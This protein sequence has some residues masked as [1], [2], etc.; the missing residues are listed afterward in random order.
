MKLLTAMASALA[1]AG[2]VACASAAAP[3]PAR[4][5][6]A[7]APA[8]ITL[9]GLDLH[10]GTALTSGT[11]DYLYGTRYGCG[12]TWGTR[13]TPWCGFGVSTAKAAGGPWATPKLLFSPGAKISANWPGDNGKT[14]A[15]MCGGDGQGC[16]NPRMLHTPNG[17]WLLWFNAP[18]DKGRH[19]NPYWIMTCSGPAGPCGSPHKPAIYSACKAGGD[20]SLALQGGTGYLVCAG[21]SRAI[22]LEP[23]ATGMTNG[24][25]KDIPVPGAVGEGD[26]VYHSS[27]GY[28]LV[29]ST[30]NCGYCSGTRAAAAGA[31]AV[32]AGY[33]TAATL[34]GPWTYR[35]VLPGGTCT[36]QPRTA[37][38]LNGT[39]YVLVDRWTGSKAEPGAA[40]ALVPTAL[41]P[42][43]CK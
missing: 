36:G 10:D 30:P 13:G 9:A 2:L 11:T 20:F 17:R 28:T 34:A 22:H 24:A 43:T 12:F 15:Q 38:A 3:G 7:P 26:G 4:A 25:D 33:A 16:F 23:L 40:L 27:G 42:W 21:T 29:L 35:G 18:G 41:D 1:C 39:S 32:S 37:L 31:V 6:T 5:A 8:T 14:W 19:A